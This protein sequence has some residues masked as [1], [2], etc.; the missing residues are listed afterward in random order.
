[1]SAPEY[2]NDRS[3]LSM[4]FINAD[5]KAYVGAKDFMKRW[6]LPN[7][8]DGE[9]FSGSNVT[10]LYLPQ[11]LSI[12]FLHRNVN[13]LAAL[14]SYMV[15]SRA[16]E[17]ARVYAARMIEDSEYLKPLYQEDLSPNCCVEIVPGT[18]RARVGRDGLAAIGKS[19]SSK[20]ID[21]YVRQEEFIGL[22]HNDGEEGHVVTNRRAVR[23]KKSNQSAGDGDTSLQDKIYGSL[24]AE[25]AAAHNSGNACHVRK[26][27]QECAKIAACPDGDPNKILYPYWRKSSYGTERAQEI[28]STANNY[29]RRLAAS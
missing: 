25:F 2:P 22:I 13:P 7:A 20:N 16:V 3:L 11:G 9:Y 12:S 5:E 8:E 17:S 19:L 15:P 6:G 10:R 27:L 28:R 18:P 24:R 23:I 26:V 29:E 21:F 14:W 4:I 1:M